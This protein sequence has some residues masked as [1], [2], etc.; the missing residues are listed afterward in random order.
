MHRWARRL[1]RGCFQ[2]FGSTKGSADSGFVGRAKPFPE[3]LLK[4][5]ILCI[6]LIG[7]M[8]TGVM[9]PSYAFLDKTR[10]VAHLGIAY[11]V[12]HHWVM[13]PYQEG[14][15]NAGADHR[16]ASLVKAGIAMLF[17]VHEV[18]VSE[19][20]AAKSKDPLLQKLNGAIAGLGGSFAAVGEKLKSGH[21]DPK[22]VENLKSLTGSIG[23]QA[24]AG[25]ATIK[26]IPVPVPGT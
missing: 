23:S 14:K 13:N 18:K 22:D 25:G 7:A 12:F 1:P 16:T 17:A 15:F 19:K 3:A 2:T 5:L 4:K 20:I 6:A 10:F 24:A 9:S 26:D 21:F 11:F 8:L